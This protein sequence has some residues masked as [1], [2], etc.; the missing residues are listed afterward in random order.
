M[1]AMPLMPSARLLFR[2]GVLAFSPALAS[3][4]DVNTEFGNVAIRGFDPVSSTSHD[5]VDPL[6]GNPRTASLGWEQHGISLA[7]L[8]VTP[9]PP[10][11]SL[12]TAIRRILHRWDSYGEASAN[13]DPEAWRIVGGKLY[14][15]SG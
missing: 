15:F 12:R 1:R 4:A 10:T 9:S 13:V 7:Q 6:K 5:T 2:L 14:L 8:T 3:A 11:H